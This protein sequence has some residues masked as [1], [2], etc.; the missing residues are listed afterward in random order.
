MSLVGPRPALA[1]ECEVF[2]PAFQA[3]RIQA[4]PGVTGLWQLWGRD[5]PSFDL[6]QELDLRYLRRCSLVRDIGILLITVPI[7]VR[8]AVRRRTARRSGVSSPN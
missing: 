8:R 1:S 7:A 6:Y 4:R 5:E 3:V 2:P